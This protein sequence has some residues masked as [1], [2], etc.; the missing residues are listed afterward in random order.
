MFKRILSILL[1]VSVFFTFSGFAS[2]KKE[3]V[4]LSTPEA[5]M[6]ESVLEYPATNDDF[7]Y[8]VYT[9]YVAITEC[10]ST[11]S[12]IIIPDTIQDL[13]VYVI[14]DKAFANQTAVTSITMT[15]NVVKIGESAFCECT[16]LQSVNL[17]KN[18]TE[19]GSEAFMD[20]DNIK[21]ITIP[22]SL[23]TI[24]S[25]MFFSCERL[26]AVTIEEE[27]AKT[28]TVS[29]N[30]SEDG[31]SISSN[32]FGS[33]GI[34]K[35]VW[36]PK[37]IASIDSSAFSKSMEN[38]TIYGEA[39][40]SAAHYASENL[41][42]FVVLGKNEFKTIASSATA[43]EKVA[44]GNSIESDEWKITFSDAYSLRSGFGYTA[45]GRQKDKKLENGNELIVLCFAVKNL[46]GN[47]RKFNFLEVDAAVNEYHHKLSAYGTI[48]YSQLSQF[49]KP[50]VGTVK[51]GEVMYGYIAVETVAGWKAATVRFL[52]DTVLEGYTFEIKADSKDIT[53]IGSAEEPAV[54]NGDTATD[55]QE[56]QP[57]ETIAEEV[58]ETTT[59]AP[60]A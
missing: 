42:D 24:P 26:T 56:E 10:L 17:S 1:V 5:K 2:S 30:N 11:K 43:T 51:S 54:N 41:L 45:A 28:A 19:C 39:Q 29:E 58:K 46:S 52:N 31:R 23:Y 59:E 16:N 55:I 21:A 18:L 13:P 49:G 3:E 9:Y 12:N 36:I 34:L 35:N 8:D 33:C 27:T 37:D 44:V 40:S 32:A 22:A 50:L 48:S 57:T 7:R 20:C 15:N 4:D 14:A 38:L 53:Y 60:V 25:K 47:D 6:A